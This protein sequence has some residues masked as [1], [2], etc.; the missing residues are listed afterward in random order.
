M[1]Q[2][3]IP[4][5][6]SQH[7]EEAAFLWL[8]RADAVGQPHYLCWEL[9]KLDHRLDAHLDALTVAGD[10]G[11]Q[12]ALEQLEAFPEHGETFACAYL[13]LVGRNQAR[14]ARVLEAAVVPAN[15]RAVVSAL[16]WLPDD[17]DAQD[18]VLQFGLS[19]DP[20][21]RRIGVAAGAIRRIPPGPVLQKGLL[22]K[23]AG[24]AARAARA[25]GELG[26]TNLAGPLRPM[27]AAADAETRFWAAWSLALLSNETSALGELRTVALTEKTYRWRA[28]DLVARRADPRS[29]IKW[30]PTLEVTRAGPGW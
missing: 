11:W 29:T 23:D 4:K 8:I 6:V 2:T 14:I 5:V 28:V 25:V 19:D 26:A 15:A 1:P 18:Y 27:L 12:F 21:A 24:V 13:G 3:I 20:L 17:R 22:D 7:A 9:S 10:A 16:G 30:L